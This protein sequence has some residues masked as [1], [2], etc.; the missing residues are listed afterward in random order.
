MLL[1]IYLNTKRWDKRLIRLYE[2]NKPNKYIQ[3]KIFSI[4]V[5]TLII[6][7]YTICLDGLAF[8]EVKARKSDVERPGILSNLTYIVF[9]INLLTILWWIVSCLIII[10]C[11]TKLYLLLVISTVGPTIGLVIHLPYILIAYLNDATYATS[12]F[13][14]YTIIVFVLFGTLDLS[15]GT[16]IG[17]LI[18]KQNNEE[19][20]KFLF[21]K[22]C[23]KTRIIAAFAV[24]I[25]VFTF[26]II[27]LIG[28][29]G[30][31][32]VM[33]PISG[34][35]SDA[36]NRLV[37]FYQTVFILGGAYLVY[38]SFFKK[39]PTLESVVKDQEEDIFDNDDQNERWRGL[40]NDEKVAE[41]YSHIMK[42]VTN[43]NQTQVSELHRQLIQANGVEAAQQHVK[44]SVR[45]SGNA[46]LAAKNDEKQ[47]LLG[48]E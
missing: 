40:S 31:A 3:S 43:I 17:A 34:S 16:C 22:K 27:L 10:C 48:T 15:F 13:V 2:I 20:D 4:A 19:N 25:P 46:S 28:M 35:I 37:G 33:I 42:I 21:C 11:K 47:E 6:N 12:I 44:R 26:L 9:G 1:F 29:I 36:P 30:T 18:N 32:I 24:I 45:D 5:V 38:R 8:R 7:V 39:T 23:N 41:F 14:Y